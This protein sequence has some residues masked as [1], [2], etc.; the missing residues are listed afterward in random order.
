MEFLLFSFIIFHL[1]TTTCANTNAIFA[2]YAPIYLLGLICAIPVFIMITFGYLT[3]RNI[4]SI[5]A[6]VT[7]QVDRQLTE[8]ILIQVL[9]VVVCILPYGINNAYTLI[10][11]GIKKDTNRLAIESF[12]VTIIGLL[13]YFYYAGSCYVFLI[14]SSRFRQSTKERLFFFC[15][16]NEIDAIY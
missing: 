8:M 14:S 1:G 3:Y 11:S 9:L 2:V 16:P 15:E 5:T 10:T 6:L 13:S 12:I 7:E 4:H